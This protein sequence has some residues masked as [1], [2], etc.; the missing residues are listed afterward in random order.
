MERDEAIRDIMCAYSNDQVRMRT[1]GMHW[2][3][4]WEAAVRAL[5]VTSEDLSRLARESM[6]RLVPPDA[7]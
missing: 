5:G 6:D 4:R 3:E 2:A 1:L 7:S